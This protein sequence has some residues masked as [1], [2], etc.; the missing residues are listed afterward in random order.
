LGNCRPSM[1]AMASSWLRTWTGLG[2]AKT[3][4]IAA[5]TIS[6]E[7]L[8]T[9]A[10]TLRRKCCR[11]L[12]GGAEQH[13]GDRVLEPGVGVRDDQLHASQAAGLQRA[14][15]RGPER[16]V[17]AV[18]DLEAQHLPV[19]VGGHAGGDDDCPGHHPVIDPRL[20]RR[21]RPGTHAGTVGPTGCGRGTR[22]PR[23][24]D[25]RRSATP[26]TWRCRSRCA[27][28]SPGHRP[29]GWR[30]RAERPHDHREQRLI[31]PPAPFQQRREERPGAQLGDPQFH[32]TGGAG[33][34]FEPAAAIG[35][36]RAPSYERPC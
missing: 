18:T 35:G 8:G 1:A 5:A 9:W 11:Q 2:W 24:P 33:G 13:R 7:P 26:R 22:P 29:C 16:A 6:A 15:E 20:C 28:F 32:V 23:C 17:L 27:A 25:R 34:S 21:W 12:Q 19:L 31:H 10:S 30:C 36:A 4:R 3:V 14:Q